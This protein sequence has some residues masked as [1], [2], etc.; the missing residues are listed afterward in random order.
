MWDLHVKGPRAHSWHFQAA[1]RKLP[2]PPKKILKSCY[3]SVNTILSY[4]DQWSDAGEKAAKNVFVALG[5]C[6]RGVEKSSPIFTRA[7]CWLHHPEVAMVASV[8][9]CQA[10][11]FSGWRPNAAKFSMPNPVIPG[12]SQH[13]LQALVFVLKGKGICAEELCKSNMHQGSLKKFPTGSNKT[14]NALGSRLDLQ[15]VSLCPPLLTLI[16]KAF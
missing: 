7:A 2:S 4:M 8:P 12:G 15:A 3:L 13:T 16:Q 1:L 5:H 10:G 14:P 6:T 11:C 9:H